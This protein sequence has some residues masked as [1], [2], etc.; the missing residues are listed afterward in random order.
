MARGNV[1]ATLAELIN[2]SEITNEIIELTNGDTPI[3]E[4]VAS[5]KRG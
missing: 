1:A 4:A 5:L 2:T 3:A